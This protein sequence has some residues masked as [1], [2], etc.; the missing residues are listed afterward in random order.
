[1]RRDQPIV[2]E[3]ALRYR[4]KALARRVREDSL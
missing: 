4:E 1:M 2:R 3:W